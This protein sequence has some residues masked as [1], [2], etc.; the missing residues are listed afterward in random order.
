MSLMTRI[1]SVT[2]VT[3]LT[4][5]VL[6]TI[7]IQYCSFCVLHA[8]QLQQRG[9]IREYNLSPY[10]AFEQCSLPILE[11]F[12]QLSIN[13]GCVQFPEFLQNFSERQILWSLCL[14]VFHAFTL[15][16]PIQTLH[17]VAPELQVSFSPNFRK[18]S[19]SLG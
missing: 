17:S 13:Q 3:F 11:P 5:L 10:I 16:L 7:F 12:C 8:H 2:S 1:T 15:R 14:V 9:C 6:T 18:T 4:A 19:T